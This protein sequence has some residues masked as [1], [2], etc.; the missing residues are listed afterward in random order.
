MSLRAKNGNAKPSR[1]GTRVV[2]RLC[3]MSRASLT[4]QKER[5]THRCRRKVCM[6]YQNDKAKE[7][8]GRRNKE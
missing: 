5:G 4:Q 3:C 1:L 6:R 8:T 7:V 2:L